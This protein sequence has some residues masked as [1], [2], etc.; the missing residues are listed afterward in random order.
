M[1]VS[2]KIN[3][4]FLAM[5]VTGVCSAESFLAYDKAHK[6]TWLIPTTIFAVAFFAV[7]IDLFRWWAK[8]YK[9]RK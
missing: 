4:Y 9:G 3:L 8:I 2:T 7:V 1:K 5:L 6:A